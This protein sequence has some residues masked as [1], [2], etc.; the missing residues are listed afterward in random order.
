MRAVITDLDRH[1]PIW[2]R[3]PLYVNG[4]R[5]PSAHRIADPRPFRLT[6]RSV[7]KRAAQSFGTI[8]QPDCLR[9]RVAIDNPIGRFLLN[10]TPGCPRFL[11]TPMPRP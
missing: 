2:G 3:A 5:T 8:P 4:F 6:A 1:R 7:C 11:P 9:T 10:W